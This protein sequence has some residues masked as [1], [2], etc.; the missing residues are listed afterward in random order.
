MIPEGLEKLPIQE[1]TNKHENFT[2]NLVPNT[3]F[4][5]FNPTGASRRERYHKTTKNFQWLI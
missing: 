4:K 2:H 3:S 1:W 5:V